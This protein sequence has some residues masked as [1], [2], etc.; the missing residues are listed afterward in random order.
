MNLTL[1]LLNLRISCRTLNLWFKKIEFKVQ[2]QPRDEKNVARFAHVLFRLIL[3]FIRPQ[4]MEHLFQG[5]ATVEAIIIAH[6]LQVLIIIFEE[7]ERILVE[8]ASSPSLMT[9]KFS[10]LESCTTF[11]FLLAGGPMPLTS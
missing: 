1:S 6:F 4:P 11:G 2:N 7:N 5:K 8:R 10:I 3:L 9:F